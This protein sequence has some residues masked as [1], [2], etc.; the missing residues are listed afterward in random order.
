MDHYFCSKYVIETLLVIIDRSHFHAYCKLTTK[1]S[2]KYNQCNKLS[3]KYRFRLEYQVL[4]E[5]MPRLCI[6]PANN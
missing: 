4:I 5:I 6:I 1:I 2:N 3:Q